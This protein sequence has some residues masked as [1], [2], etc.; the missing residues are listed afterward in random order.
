MASSA[1]EGS[2]L[3]RSCSP[4]FRHPRHTLTQ[5]SVDPTSSRGSEKL[6]RSIREVHRDPAGLALPKAL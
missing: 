5:P 4:A 2:A 1:P 6:S 3:T